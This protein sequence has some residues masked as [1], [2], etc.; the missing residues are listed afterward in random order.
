MEDK[1]AIY[2]EQRRIMRENIP[3]FEYDSSNAPAPEREII[4]QEKRPE[5]PENSAVNIAEDIAAA[6]R[7]K[8][9]FLRL[10]AENQQQDNNQKQETAPAAVII[11]HIP[12]VAMAVISS[13]AA[14]QEEKNNDN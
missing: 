12:S 2:A 13:A 5:N 9:E 10:L 4:R 3:K 14:E 7:N 8:D 6:D 11:P 1:Q